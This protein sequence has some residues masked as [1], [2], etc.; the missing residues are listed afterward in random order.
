MIFQILG[1]LIVCGGPLLFASYFAA[2]IIFAE[3]WI[4]NPRNTF[5]FTLVQLAFIVGVLFG[6]YEFFHHMPFEIDI[7]PKP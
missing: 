7:R 1:Y 4:G 3:A 6:W 2:A 5:L